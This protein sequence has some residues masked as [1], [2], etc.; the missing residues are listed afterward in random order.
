MSIRA[1]SVVGPAQEEGDM[2]QHA[3]QWHLYHALRSLQ[4]GPGLEPADCVAVPAADANA[5]WPI[6]NPVLVRAEPGGPSALGLQLPE[7]L[8]VQWVAEALGYDWKVCPLR[9]A[10]TYATCPILNGNSI[11]TSLE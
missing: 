10:Q 2:A 7:A 5:I 11:S 3:Q 4:H 9:N 8:T 6:V 1:S